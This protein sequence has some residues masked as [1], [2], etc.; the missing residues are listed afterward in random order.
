MLD[1]VVDVVRRHVHRQADGVAVE[2]LDLRL[3][4][5]IQAEAV[6]VESSSRASAA[7]RCSISSRSSRTRASDWPAGSSSPQS[8]YDLPGRTGQT[9]PQPIVTTTSA[10]AASSSG[11]QLARRPA[12]EV[13]ADLVHCLDH[14]GMEVLLR[15]AAGRAHLVPADPL[16]EGVRHL[17][18]PG[19]A[20]AE[21]EHVGHDVG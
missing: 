7:T 19:V 20:D 2:L 4:Q 18:A 11:S 10:Q 8:T 14:L 16:E 9:S 5:G 1:R 6:R 13:V 17:R 21:E 15:P 12:G 3:H